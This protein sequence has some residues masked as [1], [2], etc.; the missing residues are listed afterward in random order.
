MTL[1]WDMQRKH[2]R[3]AAAA[4]RE[5]V[6]QEG[7]A[8]CVTHGNGPQIGQLALQVCCSCQHVIHC[9]AGQQVHTKEANNESCPGA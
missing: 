2:A 9:N 6:S 1:Q 3:E 7:Y 4:L 5:L 8:L